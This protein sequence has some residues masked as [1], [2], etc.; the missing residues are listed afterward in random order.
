MAT[1]EEI[2]SIFDR[3]CAAYTFPMLDNGYVYPAASRLS[4]HYS[5]D[6]WGLV[7]ELFGFSPRAGL[8]DTTILTFAGR[9]S[10][11]NQPEDYVNAQAYQN[12]LANNPHNEDR[13]VWPLSEGEWI[14]AEDGELM[15]L[16][17]T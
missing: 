17:V 13:R 10:N 3:C 15:N 8:P 7:F 9:L 2:L 11:R 4:A 5:P 12:Y 1:H 16:I 14:D 6:N